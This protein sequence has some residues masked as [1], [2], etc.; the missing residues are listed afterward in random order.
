MLIINFHS[1]NMSRSDQKIKKNISE[2]NGTIAAD[3]YTS[4]QK[5]GEGNSDLQIGKYFPEEIDSTDCTADDIYS[6]EAPFESNAAD[7]C[8]GKSINDKFGGT[9]GDRHYTLTDS[10]TGNTTNFGFNACPAL[11]KGMLINMFQCT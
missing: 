7:Q 1:K 11:I 10:T 2:I 3:A 8:N 5:P 4:F 9:P 6:W